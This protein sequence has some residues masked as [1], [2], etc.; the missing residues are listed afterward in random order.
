[1]AL[2]ASFKIYSPVHK[3]ILP[4]TELLYDTVWRIVAQHKRIIYWVLIHTVNIKLHKN[5][6]FT[7]T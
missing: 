5:K 2:D 7:G 4:W 1:M 3:S 6:Q